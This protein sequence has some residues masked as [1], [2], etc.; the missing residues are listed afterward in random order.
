[1]RRLWSPCRSHYF[2]SSLPPS[3]TPSSPPRAHPYSPPPLQLSISPSLPPFS[4]PP[5]IHPSVRP[6]PSVPP[7]VPPALSCS[8]SHFSPSLPLFQ[9][10]YYFCKAPTISAYNCIHTAL[11]SKTCTVALLLTYSTDFFPTAS[12]TWF[13]RTNLRAHS[14]ANSLSFMSLFSDKAANLNCMYDCTC[15]HSAA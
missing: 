6:S 7:S 5:F 1:M 13:M 15:E 14:V 12:V 9:S 4:L 2:P 8:S 3:L 11:F 10:I